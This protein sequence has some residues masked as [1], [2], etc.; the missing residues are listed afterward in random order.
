MINFKTGNSKLPKDTVIG[1]NGP[2]GFSCIGASTCKCLVSID[3][4]TKK[5]KMERTPETRFTCYASSAELRFPG[6]YNS[7]W[8]QYRQLKKALKEKKAEKILIDSFENVRTKKVNKWRLFESGD[9]F[10][11][12]LLIAINNVA[13]YYLDDGVILYGY[14]KA[15]PFFKDIEL[16]PN[17]RYVVSLG[18]RFDSLQDSVGLKKKASV[19]LYEKDATGPIDYDD[20]HAF[21]DFT[22]LFHHLVHGMQEGE[23][24]KAINQRRKAN[25]FSGYSKK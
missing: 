24:A 22:G 18:G 5:R 11:K 3:P 10:S 23:P 25:Q 19:I 7:H 13:K 12:E 21:G 4:E 20:S 16:S 15:L 9:I 17:L 6:V 2:A 8:T 14:T 1:P